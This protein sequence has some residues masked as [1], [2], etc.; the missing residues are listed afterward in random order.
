MAEIKE[1]LPKSTLK[2]LKPEIDHVSTGKFLRI[3]LHNYDFLTCN[4]FIL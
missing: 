3:L 4:C 1:K 2:L